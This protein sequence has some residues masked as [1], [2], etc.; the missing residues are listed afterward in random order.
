ML[1]EQYIILAVLIVII[2][3]VTLLMRA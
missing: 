2:K 1:F 3:S